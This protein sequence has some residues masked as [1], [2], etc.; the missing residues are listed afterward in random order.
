MRGILLLALGAGLIW[1]GLSTAPQTGASAGAPGGAS[2]GESLNR[3]FDD[4]KFDDRKFDDREF[5][6]REFEHP[7]DGQGGGESLVGPARPAN[8]GSLGSGPAQAPVSDGFEDPGTADLESE[9]PP[10]MVGGSA[11]DQVF[12]RGEDPDPTGSVPEP[13]PAPA[14]AQARVMEDVQPQPGTDAPGSVYS[15][16]WNG[17]APAVDPAQG[18]DDAMRSFRLGQPTSSPVGLAVVLLESWLERDPTAL[19]SRLNDAEDPVPSS[20]RRLV[21]GFWQ[22]A[23]RDPAL[24]AAEAEALGGGEQTG[25]TTAQLELLRAAGNAQPNRPVPATSGHRDPLARA[26]RMVLLDVRA[27][28]AS[29]AGDHPLAARSCSDLI[30]LELGAPWPPHRPTLLRWAQALSAAQAHHRLH[31]DGDWPALERVVRPNDSLSAIRQSIMRQE[32][33]LL[34]CE[35]LIRRVNNVGKYI[36]PGDTLRIPTEAPNV[37]VDLDARLAVYRHGSE[38]VMAWEVG[39]GKE[40]HATPP[41]IYTVGIKQEY[42]THWVPGGELPFGHPDNP[43]GTRWIEW[44]QDGRGTHL[45]FHGTKEPD[46]VGGRVSLGCIRMRNEDVEELFALLPVGARIEVRR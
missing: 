39:I 34:V 13:N 3:E 29:Q 17:G 44:V 5:D 23:S 42:P 15:L 24:A 32:P 20:R 10:S 7:D 16:E 35:G 21:Y 37:L 8:P 31:R 12:S 33:G 22:G 41:G 46:G 2:A 1:L 14:V 27:A 26:M 6:D 28:R 43:L 9:G 4:R 18:Q 25:V 40:G 45:G 36:H 11:Q 30:Q 19:E 38:A